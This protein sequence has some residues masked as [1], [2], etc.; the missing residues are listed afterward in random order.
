MLCIQLHFAYEGVGDYQNN[1]SIYKVV[2]NSIQYHRTFFIWRAT[3]G[4]NRRRNENIL[5]K[6][7]GKIPVAPHIIFSSL[8]EQTITL[9]ATC[10]SCFKKGF[11]VKNQSF[12]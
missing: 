8:L 11:N 4:F 5:E 7:S 10:T 6:S 1:F 3:R 2:V 12:A 9:S